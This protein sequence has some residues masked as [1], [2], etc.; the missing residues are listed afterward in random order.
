MH[1]MTWRC[2][3]MCQ[4]QL[5]CAW[6]WVESL[7]RCPN[8]SSNSSRHTLASQQSAGAYALHEG[9]GLGDVRCL[10]PCQNKAH[11]QTQTQRICQRVNLAT[12]T[13]TRAAQCFGSRI[14]C[15]CAHVTVLSVQ[16]F[17]IS[18]LTETLSSI[19]WH[20]PNRLQPA[21]RLNTLFQCP[22]LS[23]RSRYQALKRNIHSTARINR[24]RV[25]SH[26]IGMPG[27]LFSLPIK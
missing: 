13:A 18:A 8:Q 27:V 14:A 23:G 1:S 4:S 25:A 10:A 22:S 6:L 19:C 9:R 24:R 11:G 26:L 16:T 5:R 15:G 21:K 12:K 3:Y 20:I 17:C 7:P 2:S